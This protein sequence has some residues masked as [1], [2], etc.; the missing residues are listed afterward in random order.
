MGEP[1]DIAWAMLWLASVEAE[2]VTGAQIV[3]DGGYT[4]R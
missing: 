3:I 4:A 1:G 2:F